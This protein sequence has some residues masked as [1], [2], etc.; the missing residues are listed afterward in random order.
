MSRFFHSLQMSNG[1]SHHWLERMVSAV[2]LP[3]KL[4][5]KAIGEYLACKKVRNYWEA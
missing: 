3:G 1:E 2:G 5:Y 4:A